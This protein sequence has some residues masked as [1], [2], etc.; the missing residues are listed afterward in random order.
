[1]EQRIEIHSKPKS[2]GLQ[3][4]ILAG[5]A[6]GILDGI[7]ASIVFNIKLGLSLG[8]VMQYVASG[9]YGKSA[10][11]GGIPMI[12]I[13]TLLHFF[14]AFTIAAGYFYA[15]TKIKMLR[16]SAVLSGLTLGLCAWLV[17]NLVV[18]PLSNTPPPPFGVRDI[19]IGII[20]HMFL[21]GLP[22]SLIT[23]RHFDR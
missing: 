8:Q 15:Y 18:L 19:L 21:V 3:T 23:K 17:M 16:S 2:D 7:A 14:T 11:S 9:I 4:I 12:L 1:M 22:I 5:L 20:L 10:F 13:G 6:A